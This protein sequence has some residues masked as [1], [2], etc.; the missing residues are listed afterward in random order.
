VPAS[1]GSNPI[2]R[3]TVRGADK[4]AAEFKRA[5]VTV[6]EESYRA[7]RMHTQLLTVRTKQHASGRPGPR[8]PTGDYRR[9]IN[10][11]TERRGSIVIG[12]VG[13]NRPQGPRLERGFIGVDS[14]G[15]HYNQPPYPHFQPAAV[16]IEASFYASH[17]AIVRRI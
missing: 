7:T 10:G 1:P 2:I 4:V 3:V 17:E 16:E 11:I 13:T 15:R 6:P 8:T 12:I 5:S 14:L 9:S